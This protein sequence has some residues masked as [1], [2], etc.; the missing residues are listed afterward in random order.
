MYIILSTKYAHFVGMVVCTAKPPARRA[1]G[2]K[3]FNIG[4]TC[5]ESPQVFPV[6][7]LVVQGLAL[8]LCCMVKVWP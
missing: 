8:T 4:N 6:Y 2:F 5:G 3:G 1:G 7:G